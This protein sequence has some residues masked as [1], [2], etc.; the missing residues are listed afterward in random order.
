MPNIEK[1]HEI[2]SMPAWR[3]TETQFSIFDPKV[4]NH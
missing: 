4:W 1:N 2:E 3:L